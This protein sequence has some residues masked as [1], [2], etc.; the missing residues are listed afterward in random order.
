MAKDKGRDENEKNPFFSP[1]I[2]LFES[3]L[4]LRLTQYVFMSEQHR[5]VDLRLSEPGLFISWREDFNSHV[6]PLPLTPPH[7]SIPSFAWEGG[8]NK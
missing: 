8:M 5:V 7:L 6:L 4:C 2:L 3:L 1:P